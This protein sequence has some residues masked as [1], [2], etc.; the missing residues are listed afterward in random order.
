MAKKKSELMA[1]YRAA[2]ME[3]YKD[4]ELADY[5]VSKCAEVVVFPNG[6]MTDIEKQ[7]VETHFCFGYSDIG[8]GPTYDEACRA[9]RYAATHEDYFMGQNMKTYTDAIKNLDANGFR[10]MAVLSGNTTTLRGL[11]WKRVTDVL[12]AVGG[13]AFLEDL[14]GRELDFNGYKGYVCTDE[15]V[16]LLRAGFERAAKSHER[17]CRAYLKRYGLSKLHTWTYWMD[18]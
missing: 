9:R 11:V 16:A 14:K 2:C 1:A 6:L 8:F 12:E 17:K 13:S 15:D 18:D 4:E 10:Y 5:C 7:K 3:N